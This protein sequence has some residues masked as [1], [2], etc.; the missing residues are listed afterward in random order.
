MTFF[1]IDSERLQEFGLQ[2]FSKPVVQ[3]GLYVKNKLVFSKRDYDELIDT[4]LPGFFS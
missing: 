3:K 4:G 1:I 2:S